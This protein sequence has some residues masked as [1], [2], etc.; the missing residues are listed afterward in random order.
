MRL[1]WIKRSRIWG[2]LHDD[3]LAL[4][5]A[6]S[7]KHKKKRRI[8]HSSI[9]TIIPNFG[10]SDGQRAYR[11][12]HCVET[13]HLASGFWGHNNDFGQRQVSNIKLG[14]RARGQ[15]RRKQT[16]SILENR[17][18]WTLV[19]PS[20][21]KIK[22]GNWNKAK[23]SQQ[24]HACWRKRWSKRCG[25]W[26]LNFMATMSALP[27]VV[28]VISGT[29]NDIKRII[30][31][32]MFVFNQK[33]C[34]LNICIWIC[35]LYNIFWKYLKYVNNNIQSLTGHNSQP[36]LPLSQIQNLLLLWHCSIKPTL[37]AGKLEVILHNSRWRNY[38][39]S[40]LI[41]GRLSYS[42]NG[43]VIVGL[44]VTLMTIVGLT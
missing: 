31:N 23:A 21:Y 32:K 42:L 35:I 11:D 3:R 28:T 19:L 39:K 44:T 40:S 5:S 6:S 37:I 29:F 9:Q 12:E 22:E 30:E 18:N 10:S 2:V 36:V 38:P 24:K 17:L 7:Q 13:K 34:L 26:Q 8:P 1:Y 14:K 15:C 25:R 4:Y 33:S 20:L 16:R 41:Y 27:C 43:T